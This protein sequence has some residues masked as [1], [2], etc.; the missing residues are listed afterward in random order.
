MDKNQKGKVKSQILKKQ[1]RK[2]FYEFL[3][4]V[5][6]EIW[7]NLAENYMPFWNYFKKVKFL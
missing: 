4:V 2:F 5:N 7:Y 6:R 3:Q 1:K